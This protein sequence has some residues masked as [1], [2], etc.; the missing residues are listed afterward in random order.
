MRPQRLAIIV[1]HPIQHFVA[2]YRALAAETDI[3]L[4][5]IFGSPIGVKPYYDNEMR[6][7]I[8]WN[9]DLL[10]G[11]DHEFLDNDAA[12]QPTFFSMNSPKLGS[13]LKAFNPD[14]VLVYG[15][16]QLNAVRAL[17]WCRR[18]AVPAMLISDS[19]QLKERGGW[20]V[21]LK[22]LLVPRIFRLSSAFLSVGDQNEGY[23][24]A[25]GARADRIFRSPFTID[26]SV[27]RAAAKDRVELRARARAELGLEERDQVTLFV[28]KLSPRKRPGDLLAAVD[29]LRTKGRSRIF[30]VFAGNGELAEDLQAKASGGDFARF[31]GFV[32][33]DRLPSLYAAADMLVHPSQ[34][35]PHP[36]ICSEGACVGLPLILSDRVGA[37]GPTDIARPGENALIFPCGDVPAL[38][39]AIGQMMDD[40]AAIERMSRRSHEIF[41]EC[42]IRQSVRGVRQ[43]MEAIT[44]G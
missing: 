16:S 5:V 26:E 36:L 19:E 20:K 28:G 21:V 34:A 18:H 12:H 38:A 44:H 1:S 35:D 30:A 8:S 40:P 27:Y 32:N 6:S 2:F 39:A 11:Y 24:R 10:S 31:A 13:R 9:M 7:Q 15:Y 25:Y 3:D 23:Y 43:A 41:D 22:N 42:D 14:A 37:A 33:V 17:L 4:R 29:L